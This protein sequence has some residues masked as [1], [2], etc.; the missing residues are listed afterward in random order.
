MHNMK[1]Y[2]HTFKAGLANNAA[3]QLFCSS[4]LL[5]FR[6]LIVSSKSLFKIL[7]KFFKTLETSVTENVSI[8]E[9]YNFYRDNKTLILWLKSKILDMTST[10]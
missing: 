6:E 2:L 10:E 5:C 4:L 9:P 7:E 1:K 3:S 8:E